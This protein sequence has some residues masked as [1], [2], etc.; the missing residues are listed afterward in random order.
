MKVQIIQLEPYDDVISVRDRLSFVNTERVL[1]VWPRAGRILRRKLD[2]VLIQREAAR[3]GTRLA[4]VT[5]DPDILDNAGDLNISTFASVNS[6]YRVAW[7]RPLNKVFV[8]RSD[9]PDNAPDAYELMLT[10]SRLR[11]LTPQQRRLQRILRVGA[12]L[13]LVA[14]LLA[15]VYIVLPSA[16]VT[17]APA[18]SQI[19]TTVS[20][21]ADPKLS[22]VNVETG[23]IPATI[24]IIDVTTQAS[25]PTTGSKDVPAA[26]ATG[27][28]LFTNQTST[29]VFIPA[30][31]VVTS[32]GTDPARFRTMS[33]LTI[34]A[35]V[36]QT[37][38]VTIEALQSSA[39]PPGNIEPNL[40]INVEGPLS[41]SVSVRNIVATRGGSIRQQ[42]VVT[43]ADY[44]NLLILAREKIR[45]TSLGE[46]SSRLSGS[47]FIVSDSITILEER[48]EWLSYSAFIDDLA[49]SLTLTMRARVQALV[50]DEQLARRASLASLAAK[51]PPGREM[52][53]ESVTFTRGAIQSTDPNGQVIFLMSASANVIIDINPDRVR[54]RLAGASMDEA[55][56]ILEREWLLDPRRPPQIIISPPI[57]GRLPLLPVRISVRIEG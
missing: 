8:D 36:G 44:D 21:V 56:N 33:D 31:T 52:S 49:D 54:Q 19:N 13:V 40:I 7:K 18:R 12:A 15:I 34:D 47:Q 53:P 3:R 38:E 41:D 43:K 17:I 1:L 10:E 42:G 37:A 28:V 27:I 5:S 35:G 30:G 51:I 6:S 26:L 24:D 55:L 32:I 4:L 45:Q 2:L 16:D 39:G 23:H 57:F 50:V 20:L 48:Q 9:R 22:T 11:A 14:A 46:F 25:I 29:A